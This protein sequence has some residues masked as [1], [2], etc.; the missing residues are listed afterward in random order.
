MNGGAWYGL[1]PYSYTTIDLALDFCAAGKEEEDT[2]WFPEESPRPEGTLWHAGLDGR[3]EGSFWSFRM[4]EALSGG[5]HFIPGSSLLPE[6]NFYLGR[7]EGN[8]RYWR[9]SAFYRS[10]YG[11]FPQWNW[12]TGGSLMYRADGSIWNASLQCGKTRP[13]R[14]IPSMVCREW[15]IKGQGD[16]ARTEWKLSGKYSIDPREDQ[17]HCISSEGAVCCRTGR[18]KAGAGGGAEWVGPPF[19]QSSREAYVEGEHKALSR[20]YWGAKADYSADVYC[21]CGIYSLEAGFSE[22][23]W[24]LKGRCLSTLP[25]YGEPD[26]PP[27]SFS[28]KAQWQR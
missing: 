14:D 28:L 27:F 16:I 24:L 3:F 21:S 20:L 7:L 11:D 18:W 19:R 1:S 22:G 26:S 17:L 10:R 9:N 4:K 6:L 8:L 23:E 5:P 15:G 12:Q 25:L 2:S 13:E